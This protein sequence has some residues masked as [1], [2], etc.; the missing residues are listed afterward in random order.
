MQRSGAESLLFLAADRLKS[1]RA[2]ARKKNSVFAH[3]SET[4]SENTED[5]AGADG[6]LTKSES[7]DE[8]E[9]EWGSYA[10]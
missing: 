4:S 8:K 3:F 10:Q 6:S 1:F 5:T 9:E 2:T 7:E